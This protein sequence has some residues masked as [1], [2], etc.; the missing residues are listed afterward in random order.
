VRDADKQYF[1]TLES[2]LNQAFDRA[3]QA[4]KKG[5]DP[6]PE[7]EIPVAKDMADRVENI[8]G[9]AG[10]ATRIR[11]LDNGR[12]REEV[13]LELVTDFVGGTVG[14]YDTR[15]GKI[16]GAVRTAVALLTEGVVAAPIEGI[17]RVEIL[18]NDDG[19]EFV[20]VYY[21]GPIRSAGGTAQA[22]SVLVADYARA[23]LDIDEYAA[24]TDET[25]RYA[26]EISLYD[27][28]TGLQYSP[29]DKET[30]FITKHM[31]IMLDGE[32]TGDEEVSGYRDLERVD[33]NSAR[34]GMCLVLAEGIALKAPK[35][36]RY[37]RQLDEVEWPWLQDLIDNT[38]GTNSDSA[39]ND[40]THIPGTDADE[41]E[42]QTK[43]ELEHRIDT[44][45]NKS[46]LE[47]TESPRVD[48]TGKYL[49]DLIA[50][51]PVFG[52]PSAAGAFRLRYGRARNHG[53]ATAGVHPATMHIVD[54]FVATG[55]QIKTE[56]PGKAGGVVPVDSIEGPTVRLANGDVR[57]INDPEEAKKLQNGVEKIIDLGEY[58]VNFG[59]FIE[60][61]HPLAP[62]AYVFEWWI[63]D[64]EASIA[65]I[66]PLRDDPTVDL[67]NPTVDSAVRWAEEYD[68]PLHP[69]YTYLWHDISVAEFDHLADVVAAGDIVVSDLGDT[70]GSDNG[71]R[72][73][74][75]S[76]TSS[77][78]ADIT[79]NDALRI[80]TTPAIRETVERLLV[81]HHQGDDSIQIP[82]WRALALSLG[83]EIEIESDEKASIGDRTWSLAD[84]SKHAREQDNGDNAIEAVN[85]V[86]PFQVRER[87]PTR[88]GS[89]MGRP[90]KSEDRDLSPA[91]HTLFPIGEAGG[92]QRNLGDAAQSFGD[93][94]ERGQISVQLGRRHCSQCNTVG[95]ELQCAEC[96]AHTEPQFKCPDCESILHPDESGRV[97][98]DHCE[99]DVTS[100][101]WQD[102]DLHQRYH[103]A[104][105]RVNEREASFEILKGVKGLTS[106]NKTPE[107]LEKGI[108]RAKHGVSS[109]KDGTVR[110]DMTDLPVTAVR[111]EELD[112]TADHFRELGYQTDISGEPLQ[113]D[114][115]LVELKVQ[116]IVL[117]DGAAEH[118]M[119]TADFVDD[120][121]T[122]YYNLNQFYQIDER[123]EL[124]GELVFGMAPHTSA[125]V[126]GRIVGFTSAAVGYAHPY[127]HAAKRRNCFHPDTKLWFRNA[128]DEWHHETIRTFVED[129]LED[130]EID[131][132]GTLV[133]ELDAADSEVSVPSIDADGNERLQSVTAVSKHHA[134]DHLVRI[135]TAS[136]REIT[137]TPDHE[138]HILKQGNLVSKQ[139]SEITPGE[140]A[141]MSRQLG[142]ISPSSHTPQYD[143]LAEFLT[144]D[145]LA[146]DRLIIHTTAP[147]QL[148]NQ[149]LPEEV[150][151][152]EDIV[153]L[154]QDTA[155]Q[156]ESTKETL[157]QQLS[158]GEIP[159]MLLR[160]FVK[161]DQ[162]LLRG[163]PDDVQIGLHR[164][165]VKIDRCIRFTEEFA[166][167]LGYY[168][169][170]G[171]FH[172]HAKSPP[173]EQSTLSFY[174]I[175][176]QTEALLSK[177]LTDVFEIETIQYNSDKT[178]VSTPGELIRRVFD[179]IVDV[180]TR[181]TEKRIPQALFDASE[182]HVESYLRS[183]FTAHNQVKTDTA[184][185][186]TIVVSREL[187][188]DITAILR[189]LG[190]TAEIITRQPESVSEILP[191]SYVLDTKRHTDAD[192]LA[193]TRSYVI[194]LTASDSLSLVHD[195]QSQKQKQVYESQHS[196]SNN[197]LVSE[198]RRAIDGGSDDYITEAITDIEY[199][200]ADVEY[201]YCLTVS[202]THSLIA[203]DLSQKQCDGDEDCVMLL[204]DGLLNFSREYLPDKRGGS[205]AA[206]SRLVAVGPDDE[207]V[208]TTFED[209]WKQLDSPINRDGKFRKRTCVSE[210][211]KTYAFDKDHQASLQPIE[212]AIRYKA[213]ES[214]QLRRITTQFGRSLNITD[215]HSL[216]RYD[217]GIE[218]VAGYDLAAGDIIVA[219]RTLD[220]ESTQTTLDV[221]EY[222]NGPCL[223]EQTG[224]VTSN[225]TSETVS[226]NTEQKTNPVADPGASGQR[227]GS[228][229]EMRTLGSA[230]VGELG[231][232]QNET[233]GLR[234]STE[235]IERYVD[236]TDSFGWLLGQFIAQESITT[237]T[238]SIHVVDKTR[239]ERIVVTSESVFGVR[240][241]VNIV[242]NGYEI[243]FPPVLNTIVSTLVL[244]I[245]TEEGIDHTHS[246]E[247]V[248]PECILHGPDDVAVS[249]LRGFISGK[250][251]ESR[252]DAVEGIDL[253]GNDI[254]TEETTVTLNAENVDIKDGLVFLLHRFGIVARISEQDAT[255]S[256]EPK[257]T[258]SVESEGNKN[259]LHQIL[260]GECPITQENIAV[261]IP[262][263]LLTIQEVLEDT[264]QISQIIPESITRQETVSLERLHSIVT[265]LSTVDL[266]AQLEAKRDELAVLTK[267]DLSYLRVENVECV[268]YDGYLYDLQ[269]GGEP[270][271]T[272]NWL[273]AHNSMDAPLVMSSRIDP[274]E[275]DDEAHNMDVVRQYPR[276][277]YEATR[278]MEDPEE[279]EEEIT[280]AEE[281]LD[282]DT[283]YTGFNH[284]HDTTDIAAGPDLSA[285]KTL[286]SM[287]D[288]MDAQL[289]LARKLRAVDETDVAERVIEYHFLPDLIGNLRA[290]SRQQTRC[291]DCGESYR[292][293]PLTGECRECGGR[294]NLTVHQGSVNKYMDTA[295]HIAEEFDCREYTKQRLEVLE[296]SLESIFEDDTNKQS[297]IADFM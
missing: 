132:V 45:E 46:G 58:L 95:F 119:K 287:M 100:A 121:L 147:V 52:H 174:D 237:D 194:S 241:T 205:V 13:A 26:E 253:E 277:F 92:N 284:T 47:P 171:I 44:V 213:D 281:Y 297:G 37:T 108:L 139:A 109:F 291:L 21:A 212:K 278:R 224:S 6:E 232:E 272:A 233:V 91:V 155:Y 162:S 8:L 127:F 179:T 80:D 214:E 61:N 35:I 1:E 149:I 170:A 263:A 18:N 183:F 70:I 142:E 122:Q 172:T 129:R 126:V 159:V 54:D 197:R 138:M 248:I 254:A 151:D 88:I 193:A 87:A 98:C 256:V 153:G 103:D 41:D 86:A 180:G 123:D 209:F 43:D 166:S 5:Y 176:S 187:K 89:R 49:R 267:G 113:F 14:D 156:L 144:Q 257:Y 4:K 235:K 249:F 192:Q 227:S 168:A 269:V 289:E 296:R 294:V 93:D 215:Q 102:I 234:E 186:S 110:Y 125:A 255:H 188:E 236:V 181:P 221:V 66:Q 226:M 218:E 190:I 240:P 112:V 140:Y 23:L 185:I 20:N 245:K 81:E 216:F 207:V 210:G 274:S 238:L 228:A 195:R 59:E 83:I 79:T 84:L 283:E 225:S 261:P 178:T 107:P 169:A 27:R 50:G 292:R 118:M 288:K 16:E 273:Y 189:R 154:I 220:V 114:N 76:G 157:M 11:E 25:E 206:D 222:I 65:D 116:D 40:E 134:P 268:E 223:G 30:K 33:T 271:F 259:P 34:G 32:A 72:S 164:E 165:E 148:C 36:Q 250:N 12:S 137:V 252:A 15:E 247:L 266:P 106:S 243:A 202:E 68:I 63:Q 22:L 173:R 135:E 53:F 295:I 201:T 293:M 242:E 28:E 208:F 111:P 42:P 231:L 275:I 191:E 90:E 78:T 10:V 64:F 7:V 141:A 279:W 57:C 60:N 133:Q 99:R 74:N 258:V 182:S 229:D 264:S 161:T 31:P 199:I 3:Q 94:N 96:G 262:D 282:T 230:A 131:A 198:S 39:E 246:S 85:E 9:I 71:N 152:Y 115:Q 280:I 265:E 51:R 211:W 163:V 82:A 196:R 130:P 145:D 117:P 158:E 217:D 101:E 184:D 77:I 73:A 56:R 2:Q 286:D 105:N 175:N 55:T 167:L 24:R 219:P 75:S 19:S 136:G 204:M 128:S 285:Y 177:A 239:V 251:A 38:I 69:A 146:I 104:L 143:L 29:K 124:I 120:L 270:V 17:D 276:G 48:A 290:F 97:Y 203:N 67:E 160:E 200:E 62:A 150:T 244:G 260:N